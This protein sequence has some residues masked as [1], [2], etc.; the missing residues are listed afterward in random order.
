MFEEKVR[1]NLDDPDD[2]M[3]NV[4]ENYGTVEE[5]MTEVRKLFEEERGPGWMV[6]M[7]DKEAQ[8]A[9]EEKLYTA[10]LA[11][12]TK[13]DKI[14]RVHDATK[15]VQVNHRIRVRDQARSP[16]AGELRTLLQEWQE[17]RGGA[18]MFA[19]IGDAS[20]AHRRI[21]MEDWG[22]PGLPTGIGPGMAGHCG[23]LRVG[24]SWILL[25]ATSQRRG[26]TSL[27][28]SLQ[29]RP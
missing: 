25:G 5:N 20:K 7:S 4:S 6:E 19:V 1:W 27:L 17:R 22:V 8:E 15:N 18:K 26:S 21:K 24:F 16:G 9:C 11:V 12:V 28:L 23:D 13:K 29:E 3:T 2:K 14:Q 10:S